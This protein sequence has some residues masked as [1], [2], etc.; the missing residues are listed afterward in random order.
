M[1]SMN[2]DNGLAWRLL[3]FSL[4]WTAATLDKET[5]QGGVVDSAL[6]SDPGP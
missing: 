6:A 2:I 3:D 4:A 1:F 5:Q